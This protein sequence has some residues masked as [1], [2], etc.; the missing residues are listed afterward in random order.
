MPIKFS[1]QCNISNK[2]CESTGFFDVIIDVDTRVFIDPALLDIC[3]EPE[4][5]EAKSQVEKYFSSIVALIKS[6]EK[7]GDMYWEKADKLLK[8]KELTGT[9]CGFAQKSTSGNAI[10]PV[11]RKSI[12][13]TIKSLLRKG[14]IEPILFELLGV[15]QE[16]IGCD[17][18]SDLITFILR[19]NILQYTQRIVSIY[20]IPT[21]QFRYDSQTYQ[22]WENPYNNKP[23]LLLPKVLMSPLPVANDF[24]D[25]SYV[26]AENERVRNIINEYFDLGDKKKLHKKQIEEMLEFNLEFRKGLVDAYRNLPKCSYDFNRDKAGEYIWLPVSREYVKQY[27]LNLNS[28]SISSIEDVL[29]VAKSICNKFKTLIEDNGLYK[30][31]YDEE[32]PK[33][34]AAAQLLFFG[35]ADGYCESNNIDLTKEGNNGRGPVDFKLSRGYDDKIVVETKLT[36]NSQLIHGIETQLPIYMKQENVKK[37]I[38]LIIDTGYEKALKNFIEYYEKLSY[39]IKVKISYIIVDATIK[40]SASTA[41]EIAVKSL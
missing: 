10:G 5:L 11:L 12:L 38:Y 29:A 1:E 24:D 6:S 37:A 36:S 39:E 40:D 4:F 30:L 3:D 28:L 8:F 33:R 23:I 41:K 14:E 2:E 17:R 31:L 13:Y 9:C 7:E 20:N 26:C 19:H 21:I 35:I 27:P 25:I 32:K 34:E 15:F 16:G 22:L 18:V